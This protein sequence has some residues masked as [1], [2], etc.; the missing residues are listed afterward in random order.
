[1]C[2]IYGELSVQPDEAARGRFATSADAFLCHRGPDGGGTWTDSR[3]LLGHR[4]LAIIDLSDRAS[5]P[6]SSASRRTVVAFNGEIYNYLELR[7]AMAPPAGGW[8]TE[9]DTEVLTEG[10]EREGERA[11]RDLVG[12]FAIAVW[13]PQ[14]GELLLIRDRLGK[15][16]L[17][18]T[19]SNGVLRF[20]S[21]F[22]ALIDR[23]DLRRTSDDRIAE[24]LQHG[25]I[26]APRTGFVDVHALP[27]AH[28]LRARCGTDGISVRIDRYWTLPERRVDTD[29]AAWLEEF[30]ATFEDAV[31]IRLRSDVPIGA[32]LS[33]GVDSSVVSLVA[34]KHVDNLRTFTVDF[35]DVA[36]SEGRFA[37][38][39]AARIGS[40]HTEL[41][42]GPT[43]IDMSLLVRT[44]G[45]LQGDPSAVP[46][47]AV[48][49]EMRRHVTVALSGDGGD[50]LLGGY[51][52]YH[53]AMR[54]V[55]RSRAMPPLLRRAAELL[56]NAWPV[57]LRGAARLKLVSSNLDELYGR[58]MRLWVDLWPSVLVGERRRSWP[59]AV[60]ASLKNWESRPALLRMMACDMDT[61][62]P[63]D[64]LVKVDRASM[65]VG[66]EVRAPLLDHRLFELVSRSEP[67]WLLDDGGAKRPLRELYSAAL[68]DHVFKRPKMG[69]GVPLAPWL[70]DRRLR[71]AESNLL[72]RSNGLSAL[73]DASEVR[74]LLG[75]YRFGMHRA[76]GHIWRLLWLGEWFDQWRPS[77]VSS[78]A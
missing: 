52:R 47:M 15:K 53:I 74:R 67:E 35:E 59:N 31:R 54:Q 33:G 63:D 21:E 44:Y 4:R 22:G 76:R 69:F 1:M 42:L 11:L 23:P 77:L 7:R 6:Y 25:S 49:R 50:E 20:A 66:L 39:V 36:F 17:Y 32:F 68:P 34:R 51:E 40:T 10:L 71:A 9:S 30:R 48:T 38:D 43:D 8:R 46:T 14:D 28:I 73:L 41:K 27:P 12:M 60:A 55:A 26:A 64:I 75:M 45:D 58:L 16:P 18:Y 37:N 65:A 72:D 29:A 62:L 3:C 24:F 56:G 13:S 70:T 57:W 78:A 5:Q 19:R 61:Y 2:G